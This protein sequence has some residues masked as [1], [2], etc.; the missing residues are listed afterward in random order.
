MFCCITYFFTALHYELTLGALYGVILIILFL[1]YFTKG[2]PFYIILFYFLTYTLGNVKISVSGL[3]FHDLTYWI[4]III[5]YSILAKN[6]FYFVFLI[7][8]I[9]LFQ[10]FYRNTSIDDVFGLLGEFSQSFSF[11]YFLFFKQVENK[12]YRK[13]LVY[14]SSFFIIF[15]ILQLIGFDFVLRKSFIAFSFFGFDLY[16]PS[17]LFGSVYSAGSKVLLCCLVIVINNRNYMLP[18]HIFIFTC[19]LLSSFSQRSFLLGFLLLKIL[20]KPIIIVIFSLMTPFFIFKYIDP[21]NALKLFMW[22][23]VLQ[24]IE[25]NSFDFLFGH[26][27]GSCSDLLSFVDFSNFA[28]QYNITRW[29]IIPTKEKLPHNIFIQMLYDFG[30]IFIIL[31]CTVLVFIGKKLYKFN[32]FYFSLFFLF[33]IN[34]NLHNGIFS[35]LNIFLPIIYSK[36]KY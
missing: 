3:N 35:Y 7:Y 26:G 14:L 33:F 22:L 28:S 25:L 16:R 1:N 21:S 24:N 29:D 6:K 17:G 15:N 31:Y 10:M 23:Y 19:I 4:S 30:F 13:V 11:G 27:T 18:K 9:V 36:N 34:F 12:L 8:L 20:N 5:L 32:I 2:D